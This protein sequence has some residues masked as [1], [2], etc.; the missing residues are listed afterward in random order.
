MG[1]NHRNFLAQQISPPSY[2]QFFHSNASTIGAVDNLSTGVKARLMAKNRQKIDA[3]FL[4]LSDPTRRA[5]V[6]R[7]RLGPASVSELSQDH[8]M[9]LPSFLEHLRK[10]EA[11]GLITSQKVGRVRTCTLVSGALQSVRSWVLSQHENRPGRLD[12]LDSF[13]TRMKQSG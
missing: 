10:L 7:L 2:P 9:A 1:A 12:R 8:D 13:V 11:A 3:V 6:E 4:A 5:V